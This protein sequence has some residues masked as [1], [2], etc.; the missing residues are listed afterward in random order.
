MTR[1][2]KID[3][4][5]SITLRQQFANQFKTRFSTIAR[6]ARVSIVDND[7]F[8]L[9]K[10]DFV[11]A[12]KAPPTTWV[13]GIEPIPSKKFESYTNEDKINKFMNWLEITED[14]A[15]F[16][17]VRR[18]NLGK[19]LKHQWTDIYIANSFKRGM[20]WGGVQIKKDKELIH[21]LEVKPEDIDT[22]SGVIL[23]LFLAAAYADKIGPLYS[24]VLNDLKGIVAT[25]NTNISRILAESLST[26]KQPY[27]ISKEVFKKFRT[28]A[29]NR[30]E[31][32]A[33][34][35]TTR[36]HHIA[37][38][39]TYRQWKIKNIKINAEWRTARDERV[40]Q[41]CAPLDG[42]I[43]TLDEIEPL[44]PLHPR[45]RCAALPTLEKITD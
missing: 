39:Q 35:E 12:Q 28:I 1:R 7:C 16:Q 32:L 23:S 44:I 8:G 41:L 45:C 36:A 5:K 10:S 17:T 11:Q 27:Y 13:K 42:K 14:Q 38:I 2:Y 6:A 30:A 33:Q 19:E 34:T 15:I 29:I 24:R 25:T 3:P 20:I 43:Y 31:I 18:R 40:C 26:R 4:T 22:S 37:T 9:I 21:E